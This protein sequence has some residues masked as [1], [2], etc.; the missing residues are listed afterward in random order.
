MGHVP[1]L[2][3]TVWQYFLLTI[4]GLQIAVQNRHGP[5]RYHGLG[6]AAQAEKVSD[7]GRVDAVMTSVKG[8]YQLTEDGPLSMHPG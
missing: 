4:L 1:A 3:D 8:R 6:C 5:W 7:L 2:V